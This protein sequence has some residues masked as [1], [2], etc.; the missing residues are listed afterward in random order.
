[1]IVQF[2]VSGRTSRVGSSAEPV[3]AGSASCVLFDIIEVR[4]YSS[5]VTGSG[6]Y[7][8]VSEIRAVRCDN[9]E[10]RL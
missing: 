1:M 4:R 6:N 2:D 5:P 8:H 7:G 9:D 3:I 10:S